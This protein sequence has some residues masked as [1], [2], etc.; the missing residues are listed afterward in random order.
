MS[1]V[2]VEGVCT[3]LPEVKRFYM[4][5]IVLKGTC[6]TCG[7][8][9][10]RDLGSDYLSYGETKT[11]LTCEPDDDDPGW[12]AHQKAGKSWTS[13]PVSLKAEI[14]LTVVEGTSS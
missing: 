6:P 4:P 11:T 2:T 14:R 1:G 9:L 12:E 10:E 3:E 7:K 8:E 13:I 5:G